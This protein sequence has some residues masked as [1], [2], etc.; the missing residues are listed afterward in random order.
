MLRGACAVLLSCKPPVTPQQNQHQLLGT[1]WP[2]CSASASEIKVSAFGANKT[3]G[4]S[5]LRLTCLHLSEYEP[6]SEEIRDDI[7]GSGG[8]TAVTITRAEP[9][10]QDLWY[11]AQI[12]E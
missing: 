5:G 11:S 2:T 10:L 12:A 3:I 6:V 8:K 7:C 4:V 1:W 9:I